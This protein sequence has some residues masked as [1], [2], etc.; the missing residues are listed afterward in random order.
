[1]SVTPLSALRVSK[2]QIPA[3]KG[4]PNTSIQGRPLLIYH[5]VFPKSSTSIIESHL[6]SVGEVSPQ[7]RYTMYS[8]SHF[9]SNTHE[10]LAIASGSAKCCFGH[11]DNDGR[12]E[13]I[14]EKGDVVIIPAGVSHRLIQ[15]YG[16]FQMVG[17][18][19]VGNSWDM[20]YGR[21]DEKEQ[22][23]QIATLNWFTKD[24]I[25]GDNGPCLQV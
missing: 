25:Y 7:W 10:V 13:P 19:P 9:H 21:S 24:P 15:D 16:G 20:C 1:M 17:S 2:H 11:E 5:G 18:Y 3:F 12:V 23:K 14:L 22:V 4:F 6:K 8:D